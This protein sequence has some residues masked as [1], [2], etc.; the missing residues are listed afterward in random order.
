MT[1]YKQKNGAYNYNANVGYFVD[2][3]GRRAG[4]YK[5]KGNRYVAYDY[6]GHRIGYCKTDSRGRKVFYNKSGKP[7]G[8]CR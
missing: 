3:K 4:N 8:Y 5:K 2:S 7:V 6:K 1:T